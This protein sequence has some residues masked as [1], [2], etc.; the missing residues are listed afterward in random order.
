MDQPVPSSAYPVSA[1]NKVKRLHERGFYDRETIWKILDAAML[2]HVSYVI[3]GQPFCTPTIHWRE[4]DWLYWHGSSA[5]RMLRQLK[6]GAP[7]CLTVSHLDGLVLSRCG[8]NHS[9]NHRSAM[10]FGIAGI[11]DDPGQKSRAF[12]ALIE[13]FYPGRPAMMRANTVQEEKATM[14]IGMQIE[15][16]S[17]KVRAKGAGDND[18]DLETPLWA[19]VIPVETVLRSPEI[20][21]QVPAGTAVPP[22]VRLYGEGRRLD[23]ALLEAQALYEA[24]AK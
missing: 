8:F 15:E 21:P 4:G 9:A 10:C 1:R 18:E 7:V 13:R 2:C 12:D 17:A 23:D 5:S 14:V 22:H 16:A 19:G 24:S 3:D 6:A 20:S 11:V